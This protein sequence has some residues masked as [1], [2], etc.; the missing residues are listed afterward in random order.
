MT[1]IST[2]T[3]GHISSCWLLA[4]TVEEMHIPAHV[5]H[6][7]THAGIYIL[8]HSCTI[9]SC[10]QSDIGTPHTHIYRHTST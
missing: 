7:G 6:T 9:D 3:A 2:L 10:A 1:T 8:S 5:A 4:L